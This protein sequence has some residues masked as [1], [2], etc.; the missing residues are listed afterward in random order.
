MAD[1]G[2]VPT[3]QRCFFFGF[4]DQQKSILD[5]RRRRRP[6]LAYDYLFDVVRCFNLVTLIRLAFENR[7]LNKAIQHTLRLVCVPRVVRLLQVLYLKEIKMFFNV[8]DDQNW[9]NPVKKPH[10]KN[11]HSVHPKRC[12]SRKKPIW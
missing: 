11:L 6:L 3:L 10:P 9:Q 4:Y 12:S 1:I 8:K 5:F 2:Q 7:T